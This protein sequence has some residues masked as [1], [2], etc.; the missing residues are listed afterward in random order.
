MNS[1]YI[2]ETQKSECRSE[3]YVMCAQLIFIGWIPSGKKDMQGLGG[4]KGR[5]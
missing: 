1:I 2:P 3:S 4:I 5:G